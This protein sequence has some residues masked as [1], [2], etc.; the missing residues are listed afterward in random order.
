[1]GTSSVFENIMNFNYSKDDENG[2]N[3]VEKKKKVSERFLENLQKLG[4]SMEQLEPALKRTGNQLIISCAGSGK[5]TTLVFKIIYNLLTGETTRLVEVN[6]GTIRVPGKIWVSTFLKSGALELESRMSYWQRRVGV[7]DTASSVTFS[8][9]H[10]EF[11]RALNDYGVET[12]IISEKDNLNLLKAILNDYIITNEQGKPLN[13]GNL[14]DL[15]SAL[16][17]TRNR[18]D[19]TRYDK[20]VYDDFNMTVSLID[21][22]LRDWKAKRYA[23]GYVDFEDLQEELFLS[24]CVKKDEKVIKFIK[25]RYD[26]LYLDEFQDISQIQYEVLKVY[27]S[28]AK[29][30]VAIGDDDQTIYSWRGSSN[31]IITRLFVNDFSPTI[32]ELSLNFRCPENILKAVV[33]SIENNKNRYVK[34]LKSARKGGELRVGAYPNYRNMSESLISNVYEDLSKGMT[35]AILCRVNSDGLLPAMMLDKA[36]RFSFSISGEGMTL[37]SYVGRLVIGIIRMFTESYSS[38]VENSLNLLTREKYLVSKLISV[39]KNNRTNIWQ[40]SDEDL[41]YSCPSIYSILNNWRKLRKAGE[42]I[43][44]LLQAFSY[45]RTEVFGRDSNFNRVA[46]SVIVSIEGMLLDTKAKTAAEFLDEVETI[47]ERLKARRNEKVQN[48]VRIATVHEFKGKEADSVYVWNDT[49]EVFPHKDSMSDV[50]DYEEERRVHYI[51]CTRAKKV[52]TIMYLSGR[53]GDFVK[54]MNL[55]GAT[56]ISI[57]SISKVLTG[58]KKEEDDTDI[59]YTVVERREEKVKIDS[60]EDGKS[61]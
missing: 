55:E 40:L 24:C 50:D 20:S 19:A 26:Y 11:K 28:G 47:N 21:A 53:E 13:S 54:E 56:D 1:M 35:V 15:Q 8:T 52:S 39:C 57:G 49:A 59:M 30:V 3:K 43:P 51:A 16:T 9:L 29:K 22:I 60:S 44:A 4:F 27:I 37:D 25:D 34:N 41:A 31:E 33:P 46:R 7:M 12:R 14:R 58:L 42:D 48:R 6:G 23:L 32:D 36:Q 38:A 18:I 61:I 45:Y 10:A 5:T 2:D 17:Y